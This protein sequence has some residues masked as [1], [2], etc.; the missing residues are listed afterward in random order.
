MS[1]T[2]VSKYT[3][4][5]QTDV[6]NRYNHHDITEYHHDG[7]CWNQDSGRLNVFKSDSRNTRDYTEIEYP[8]DVLDRLKKYLDLQNALTEDLKELNYIENPGQRDIDLKEKVDIEKH[9][10]LRQYYHTHKQDLEEKYPDK[11]I[12]LSL[13]NTNEVK[14]HICDSLDDLINQCTTYPYVHICNR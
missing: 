8:T 7:M 11:I 1:T 13:D 12:G 4:K 9:E 14:I 10:I 5:V 6:T 3:V 2:K